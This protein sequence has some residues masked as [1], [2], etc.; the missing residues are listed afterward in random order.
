MKWVL[1]NILFDIALNDSSEF[2]RYM[3]AKNIPHASVAQRIL[4][5]QRAY[6]D[7]DEYVRIAALENLHMLSET[8]KIT[9]LHAAFSDQS[10]LVRNSATRYIDLLPE[11]KREEFITTYAKQFASL[12]DLAR[13]TKLYDKHPEP[14]LY[15]EFKK[16]GTRTILYDIIPGREGTLRNRAIRRIIPA[17]SYLSWAKAY[18]AVDFWKERGFDYIPIEPIIQVKADTDN[19]TLVDVDTRVIQGP[20]ATDWLFNKPGNPYVEAINNE[21]ERINNVL[22]D[23][24]IIHGH[25]HYNNFVLDFYKDPNGVADLT[26]PPR[27]YV[28]DFDQ[29]ESEISS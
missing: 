26:R 16:S 9:M 4:L 8:D 6:S 3:A 17:S 15:K 19:P 12:L 11:D 27:L 10:V 29:S 28:I 22:R 25:L 7:K 23:L 2:V 20:S 21:V 5:I 13:K 1:D 24:G 14:F 18:E